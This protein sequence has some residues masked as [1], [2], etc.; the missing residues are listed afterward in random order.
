MSTLRSRLPDA[1]L[2]ALDR[3][4][5]GDR[6]VNA[7]AAALAVTDNAV[8]GHLVALEHDGL[9]RRAGVQRSGQ[10]GQ[11]AA[12]YEL[13]P[14]GDEAL[15]AVYP[16]ALAAL[17]AAIGGRLDARGARALFTDAGRRLGSGPR[18]EG[19][20]SIAVRAQSCANLIESLGGSIVV[21]A[22]RGR[23]TL[24]GAGC[25]LARAVRAEPGTCTM[26]ES[27]LTQVSGL[28]VTQRCA[29]GEHPA[30]RFELED[31]KP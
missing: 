3:V 6:T 17:V 14:A 18:T 13:T 9:L 30:C 29:H 20:G 15:S 10:A 26:I 12:E 27:M 7:I 23:A 21:T 11:P 2:A 22:A 1:R 8:R 28:R 24:H 31:K 16:A 5:R 25:P 19:G 4:R